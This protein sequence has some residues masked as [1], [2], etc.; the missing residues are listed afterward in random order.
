MAKKRRPSHKPAAASKGEQAPL[1]LPSRLTTRRLWGA[2]GVVVA[3][4]AAAVLTVAR[5]SG[6]PLADGSLLPFPTSVAA[7]EEVSVSAADF[8]GSDACA[9]CHRSQFGAQ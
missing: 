1:V 4:A 5:R 2:L 7:V 6:V 9:S 8:V 3:L